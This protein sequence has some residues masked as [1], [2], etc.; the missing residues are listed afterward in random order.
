MFP[1]YLIAQADLPTSY[2]LSLSILT[3]K[4]P[5]VAAEGHTVKKQKTEIENDTIEARLANNYYSSTHHLLDDLQHVLAELKESS[6]HMNGLSNGESKLPSPSEI[7]AIEDVLSQYSHPAAS[8]TAPTKTPSS[9]H[10]GQVITLRSNDGGLVRQLFTGLRKVSDKNVKLE[11][12]D[13]RKLPSGFDVAEAAV[14]DIL[15]SS[16]NDSRLFG[17]VFRPAR[18]LRPLDPPKS[19][20]GTKDNILEFVK[21]FENYSVTNKD[22]Y[23]LI[24]LSAGN[25]LE[26]AAPD[27]GLGKFPP[28]A[29]TNVKKDPISLFKAT[30]TSFAP[31]QDSSSAVISNSDRSRQWF[32]K[33]GD[34]VMRSVYGT[35]VSEEWTSS[36]YPEIDDDYQQLIDTF[37]P[38]PEEEPKTIPIPEEDAEKDV[39]EE[40]SDLLQTLSSYQHLRDLDRNRVFAA[41][42][43][44]AGP[45]VEVY[46][47]LR[48][49]LELL[50][51]A[52][53]PYAIAKLD[54]DQLKTLNINT[55]I[56][57]T[58]PD[59]AGTGQPDEGSLQR[60]RQLH[61]QQQ[62]PVRPAQSRNSYT[63]ATPSV[64]YSSQA[65]SYNSNIATTP[66]MPG[67][68]QRGAQMYNTPRPNIASNTAAYSQVPYQQRQ[69]Q[70]FPGA[71]IQQY[72]RLQNGYT[73]NN[74]TPYQ[75]RATPAAYQPQAQ[76]SS[77]QYGRP[78]SPAK[79]LVN[80]TPQPQQMQQYRNSYSTPSSTS[81]L[82]GPYAQANAHATIQQ[83]KAAHQMQQQQTQQSHSQSP[84]PQA[85]QSIQ[86]QR[87]A[88]G[89]PQPQ[90][91]PRTQ[92]Q[93]STNTAA[94]SAVNGVA[95][96]PQQA[97]RSTPTPTPVASAGA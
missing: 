25:W 50:V 46:N 34:Q 30:F 58:T 27:Y 61:A 18:N 45:E 91:Q 59:V 55:S 80:G 5:K 88:S 8:S 39:L 4:L 21:P 28:Y 63:T 71:T 7:T 24:A 47:L 19:S 92:S 83:V 6:L 51:S 20:R 66:S 94:G 23:R 53:P 78:N 36:I 14:P 42:T 1:I 9:T 52:L 2:D 16:D 3:Y 85:V 22:D 31:V 67:Y 38:A 75:P 69:Q 41:S 68:A 95:S 10:A 15:R 89:T 73:Q 33:Y 81:L 77:Q 64:A 56:I 62:P 11:E 65:R 87:Q 26:Y 32:R 90:L 48:Q 82:Q 37:L 17:D 44:P 49:Q 57:V 29:P 40:I 74:Q 84:Q 12:I 97:A 43:K 70:P 13:V 54:G 60:A 93:S 96:Q 72:Q 76:S 79:A 86:Q 35:T